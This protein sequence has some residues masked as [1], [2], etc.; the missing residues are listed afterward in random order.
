M[1]SEKKQFLSILVKYLKNPVIVGTFILTTASIITKIIGFFYRIFL[2]RI[3]KSEG[4]GII[5]LISPISV[6]IYSLCISGI[7]NA[8]TRFVAASKNKNNSD[9]FE[10]LLSGLFISTLLSSI[11]SYII[12][13]NA[14]FIS[15]NIFNEYRCKPLLKIVAL[16]FPMA[17]VHSCING[18]FYGYKKTNLPS[19]SMILEQLT[20]VL[21]VYLLYIFSQK[22]NANPSLSF[23]C[24]GLLAGEFASSCFSSIVLFSSSL[25]NSRNSN[26]NSPKL[27]IKKTHE[28][29]TLSTPI[30]LNRIC[31][32]LLSTLETIMIPQKLIQNGIEA[33]K[34]LS[35]Y[36]IFSGMALPLILFPSAITTSI[37]SLI[38]PSVSEA[39]AA[40]NH[41]RIQKTISLT[42]IFCFILGLIC[43]ITFFSLA[44]LFGNHIFKNHE[45]SVQIKALSL[46]CPFFYL[47]GTLNS[48]MHGLGKAGLS[49]IISCLSIIIRL[50]FVFFIIPVIGFNGYIYGLL[51]S[52]LFLDLVFI[53]ALRH[54]IIYN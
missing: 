39:Q 9:P 14:F 35:I 45:A 15:T 37:S 2:S 42:I 46:I 1:N 51:L 33:S 40:D 30:S 25:K 41:Q 43:M 38:L 3:F 16:S 28:L 21:T 13:K 7:Q 8:I 12:Y 5:G 23:V 48:I 54:Y 49:F 44:D 36:G 32:S 50:L 11:V 26:M 18:Y 24:I 53:L 31:I 6:F 47:S 22:V 10:Y 27:F 4:L 34:A 20:R 52:Q 19:Y 17:A 29:L